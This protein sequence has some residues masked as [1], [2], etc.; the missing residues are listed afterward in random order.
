MFISLVDCQQL[1]VSNVYIEW[2]GHLD[3]VMQVYAFSMHLKHLLDRSTLSIMKEHV[4]LL[5]PT[6]AP[7]L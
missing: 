2:K 1:H 4:R 6:K 3:Q 5:L 7:P